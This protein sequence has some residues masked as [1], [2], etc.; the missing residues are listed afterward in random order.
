LRNIYAL[1]MGSDAQGQ[2][3]PIVIPL[4]DDAAATFQEWREEH[5]KA[6]KRLVGG[7]MYLSNWGKLPGILLRLA[8]ILELLWRAPGKRL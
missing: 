5:A 4:E 6:E 7:G 1:A 8:L 2:P 3:A